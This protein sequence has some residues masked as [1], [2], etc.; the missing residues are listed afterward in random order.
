MIMAM[1]TWV[2]NQTVTCNTGIGMELLK[3]VEL[4][5]NTWNLTGQ[6]YVSMK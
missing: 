1:W 4:E 6:K 2:I 3:K 5:N